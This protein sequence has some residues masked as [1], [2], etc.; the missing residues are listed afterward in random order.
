MN[1]DELFEKARKA[2]SELFSDT[3]V[4]ADTTREKLEE[5]HADIEGYLDTLPGGA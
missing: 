2:I 1:N 4:D 5:L 3:S